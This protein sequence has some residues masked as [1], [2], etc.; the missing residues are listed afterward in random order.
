MS[1]TSSKEQGV[2]GRRYFYPLIT[3]F[4]P[5]KDL[6]SAQKENLPVANKIADSVICLPMHHAL[7]DEDVERVIKIISDSWAADDRLTTEK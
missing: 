6:P 3:D 5:Y 1:C 2:L 4:D 7:A